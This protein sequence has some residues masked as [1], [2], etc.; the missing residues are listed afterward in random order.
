MHPQPGAV[1]VRMHLEGSA[2]SVGVHGETPPFPLL[3]GNQ[4]RKSWEAR[5]R[6]A[7]QG[8]GR[9]R[10]AAAPKGVKLRGSLPG[11]GPR[12]RGIYRC[13]HLRT[14]GARELR[15]RRRRGRAQVAFAF[16]CFR[17]ASES[18]DG[19][20]GSPRGDASALRGSWKQVPSRRTGPRLPS[21]GV[22]CKKAT[23][24]SGVFRSPV[25]PG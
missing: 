3:L 20:G 19:V 25:S 14:R 24:Q 18:G 16:G 10:R 21:P 22:Q 5:P 2:S 11:R 13:G 17:V 4:S 9:W 23:V 1:R 7:P 15:G 6:W 12:A 8:G